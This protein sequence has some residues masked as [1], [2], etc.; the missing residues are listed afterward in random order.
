MRKTRPPVSRP[1]ASRHTPHCS[2]NHRG[3]SD[4][5]CIGPRQQPNVVRLSRWL[6]RLFFPTWNPAQ[7]YRQVGSEVWPAH[8][9]TCHS[10][11]VTYLEDTHCIVGVETLQQEVGGGKKQLLCA[12][13]APLRTCEG[14]METSSTCAALIRCET[15]KPRRGG[16]GATLPSADRTAEIQVVTS[17]QHGADQQVSVCD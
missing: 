9:P 17:A 3:S 2:Q 6:N 10:L 13:E 7:A 14:G 15:T 12:Q 4:R 1:P 8:M 11:V 5:R 16:Q